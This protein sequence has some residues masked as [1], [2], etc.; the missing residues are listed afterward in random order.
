MAE[1]DRLRDEKGNFQNFTC[2]NAKFSTNTSKGAAHGKAHAKGNA[3]AGPLVEHDGYTLWLEHVID[4]ENPSNE[5]YWLMWYQDGI[6]KIPMSGV[7]SK[8][9]LCTMGEQIRSLCENFD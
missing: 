5:R 1:K 7:L 9:V 2:R 6:P 3:L 8:E 4:H